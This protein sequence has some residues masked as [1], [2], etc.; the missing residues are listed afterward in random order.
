MLTSLLLSYMAV[1]G[2]PVATKCHAT[3]MAE[4]ALR[5]IDGFEIVKKKKQVRIA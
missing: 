2:V 1:T 5:V 4:F 3:L